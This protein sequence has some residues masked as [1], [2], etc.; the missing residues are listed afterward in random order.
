MVNTDHK[1]GRNKRKNENLK[2][3]QWKKEYRKKV[4]RKNALILDGEN[5]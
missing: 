4:Y 3:Q 5:Y 2:I 1:G